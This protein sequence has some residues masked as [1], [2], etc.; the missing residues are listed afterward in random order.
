MKIV[1][2]PRGMGKTEEL[3]DWLTSEPNRWLVVGNRGL[4]HDCIDRISMRAIPGAVIR[5]NPPP[6]GRVITV[7]QL[8]LL[9]G[10]KVSGIAVDNLEVIFQHYLPGIA[11]KIEIISIT[12][13]GD[14]ITTR[15]GEQHGQG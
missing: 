3:L 14:D 11:R 2:M 9:Q 6:Q 12:G 15:F 7:N 13:S 1:I 5:N 8:H 10:R 4:Q